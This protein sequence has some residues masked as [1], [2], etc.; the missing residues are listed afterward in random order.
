MTL[1]QKE[2]KLLLF[3]FRIFFGFLIMQSIFTF[4]EKE[5]EFLTEPSYL[6]RD[7][8]FGK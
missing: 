6:F 4:T 5:A 7:F 8:P 1:S 3:T 2:Y